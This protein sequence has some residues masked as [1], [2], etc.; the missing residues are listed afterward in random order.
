[1]LYSITLIANLEFLVAEIF[2]WSLHA[3]PQP[4]QPC[5]LVDGTNPVIDSGT[6]SKFAAGADSTK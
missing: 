4:A 3:D 6:I 2:A 5:R 1:M